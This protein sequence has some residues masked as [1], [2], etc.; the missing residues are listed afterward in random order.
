[1]SY[2]ENPKT[3]GSGIVCCAPQTTQ[4]PRGCADCFA[5]HEGVYA[6]LPNIPDE[7]DAKGRVVRIGDI[8]DAYHQ[9]GLSMH[10]AN[11]FDDCFLNTSYKEIFEIVQSVPIVLTLN[12]G[13]LTDIDFHKLDPIPQNLMFVRFRANAWNTAM[14]REAIN[15]YTPKGVAV[16]LTWMAYIETPIPELYADV[17][18]FRQRTLNSY[19]CIKEYARR[20]IER[21]Y[22][23]NELVYS[24]GKQCARCGNCI[25][26]YNNI[27][28]RLRK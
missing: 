1:M 7:Q 16:I 25:R 23:D 19:W 21:D 3:K 14:M 9:L 12:P 8:S 11:L 6:E 5:Q 17:Y 28:E 24:C 27:K 20:R 22:G 13:E 2:V 18:E 26:E 4:C 15:Y 10:Y